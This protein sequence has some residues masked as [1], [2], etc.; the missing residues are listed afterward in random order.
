[1]SEFHFGHSAFVDFPTF[2]DFDIG[3]EIFLFFM[4][5]GLIFIL[6]VEYNF[7]SFEL[8]LIV[9]FLLDKGNF[10]FLVSFDGMFEFVHPLLKDFSLLDIHGMLVKKSIY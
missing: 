9:G 4:E 5:V 10:L 6:G 7:I 3:I 1:M 2:L 8:L